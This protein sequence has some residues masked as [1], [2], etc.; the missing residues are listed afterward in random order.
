MAYYQKRNYDE[1]WA[2]VMM[3]KRFGGQVQQEFLQALSAA[4]KRPST[5]DTLPALPPKKE[6]E[7]KKQPP[8]RSDLVPGAELHALSAAPAPATGTDPKAR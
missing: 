7:P 2:D 1:A 3:C 6:E 4:T 5:T 8:A